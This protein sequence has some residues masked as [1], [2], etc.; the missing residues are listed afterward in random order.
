[1]CHFINFGKYRKYH[2]FPD[3]YIIA[4]IIMD[5][6]VIRYSTFTR[7]REFLLKHLILIKFSLLADQKCVVIVMF[8]IFVENVSFKAQSHIASFRDSPGRPIQIAD[9]ECP[10]ICPITGGAK[11]SLG[12]K[13]LPRSQS[14]VEQN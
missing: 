5:Y 4:C 14:M 9:G 11:P 8:F 2:D 1:M 6:H 7:M 3:F 12:N 13:N 10:T